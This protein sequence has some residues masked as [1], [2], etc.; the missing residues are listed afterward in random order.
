MVREEVGETGRENAEMLFEVR[1]CVFD[2]LREADTEYLDG[3]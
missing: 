3:W 2:W 1:I